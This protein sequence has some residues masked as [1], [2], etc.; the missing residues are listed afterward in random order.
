MAHHW[1]VDRSFAVTAEAECTARAASQANSRGN[2]AL[3]GN[4]YAF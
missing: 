2:N 3:D 4:R 1:R